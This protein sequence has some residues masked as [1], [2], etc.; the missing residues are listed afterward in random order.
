[1]MRGVIESSALTNALVFFILFGATVFSYVFRSLGGDYV[2]ADLL[3]AAGI[4]SAWDNLLF[5]MGLVFILG[6]FSISL[7]SV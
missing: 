2:F 4:D 3:K 1:M 5:L 7:R 6:F